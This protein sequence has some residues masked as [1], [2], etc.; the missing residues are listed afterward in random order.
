MKHLSILKRE[1]IELLNIKYDGI[2]I[3][4]TLGRGGHSMRLRDKKL[5]E[6]LKYARI[7]R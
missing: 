2:Y 7:H 5:L 1:T 3:D 6:L 4:G